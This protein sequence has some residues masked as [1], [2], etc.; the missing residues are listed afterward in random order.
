MAPRV[1]FP[2]AAKV[3]AKRGDLSPNLVLGP[4]AEEQMAVAHVARKRL[5]KPVM[6]Y[7]RAADGARRD[8]NKPKEKRRG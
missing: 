6:P 3:R 8:A 4:T 2:Q 7:A 5:M 1:E